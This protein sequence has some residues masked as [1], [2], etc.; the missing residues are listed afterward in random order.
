MLFTFGS[1]DG[2]N[3]I[4]ASTGT[5][6]DGM[7]VGS[8]S[9]VTFT[10]GGENGHRRIASIRAC[11]GGI[12]LLYNANGGTGTMID[13]NNPYTSGST[14]TTMTND[15]TAPTDMEFGGWNTAVDGSGDY[16]AEGETFTITASTT[17]YAQWVAPSDAGCP[18]ITFSEQG[19]E[20]A[21]VVQSVSFGSSPVIT[22]T[23]SQ[24]TN[25][26]NAPKY[27]NSGTAIRAY[28]G[29][30]ITV[31]VA[32]FNVITSIR[33]IFGDGGNNNTI[34]SD[35]GT[36]NSGVW[37]GSETSVTFTIGGANG[38][39][40]IAG[41]RVCTAQP[42]SA[43]VTYDGNGASG[44]VTDNNSYDINATV[45]VLGQGNLENPCNT[46]A[47][48]NT[49]ADGSGISYQ[50]D[51]TFTIT[52]NVTLYAQWTPVLDYT[53]SWLANGQLVGNHNFGCGSNINVANVP[54]DASV[55]SAMCDGSKVFVGWSDEE[56]EET[57]TPSATIITYD[58]FGDIAVTGDQK[59]YA[60]FAIRTGSPETCTLITNASTLTAGDSIVIVAE[61]YNYAIS[62]TQNNNNRGQAGID[63]GVSSLTLPLGENVCVF[64]LQE[65]ETTGT[66][67]FYD[68]NYDGNGGYL[69]AASSS[70]NH[71]RTQNPN[72]ANGNWSINI[73][74]GIATITAQG[75]NT[76]NILR[77]N[78]GSY[79]F[80]CYA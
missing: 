65:G 31:S 17:L 75:S 3:D 11:T 5:Y 53:I 59:Y 28:S 74:N 35:V 10:V 72:N 19:Y 29:N 54:E 49:A 78:N 22:A 64:E 67:A 21:T 56:F 9:S 61:S 66:W 1:S 7:W 38:H 8:A 76:H 37:S 58:D 43:T 15:F 77:Y 20:D 40:R 6:S 71:L 52:E 14:V 79:I 42:T 62:T 51:S 4:T 57:N 23:F 80:S 33:L 44:E 16:Y 55:T 12:I 2:S 70:S 18:E 60:V 46:F 68:A 47:G 73:T 27:Y 34:T 24:G 36:Y 32:G 26:S 41:I 13:T 63:K 48:W 45:T 30:T 69:Y 39:R 50:E 25:G